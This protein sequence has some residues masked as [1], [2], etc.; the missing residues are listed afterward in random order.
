MRGG[1]GA[2]LLAPSLL[3]ST[4]SAQDAPKPP[5][6]PLLQPS[7]R[8]MFSPPGEGDFTV[9]E[10]REVADDNLIKLDIKDHSCL[11]G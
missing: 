2:V 6:D 7:F 5:T 4:G 3:A 9:L 10:L 11:S 1:A 8:C